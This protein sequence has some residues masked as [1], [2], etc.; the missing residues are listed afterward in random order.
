VSAGYRNRYGHPRPEVLERYRLAGA[1]VLRTD[2]DGAVTVRL[3][4]SGVEVRAERRLRPRYWRAMQR[5]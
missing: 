4:P 3:A 1:A 2:L 5:G